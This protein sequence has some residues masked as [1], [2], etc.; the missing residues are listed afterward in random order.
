MAE[1]VLEKEKTYSG[2]VSSYAGSETAELFKSFYERC[3]NRVK[4]SMNKNRFYHSLKERA[5]INKIPKGL[6]VLEIGCWTGDLISK[7]EPS[8]GIGIDLC[9]KAISSAKEKYPDSTL[10][11]IS[12]DFLSVEIRNK[13]GDVKFDAIV[14]VNTLV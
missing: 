12:G 9:E 13:I 6:K 11:F 10:K 8:Y 4:A 1:T 3:F 5:L 7:L 14:I 2:N